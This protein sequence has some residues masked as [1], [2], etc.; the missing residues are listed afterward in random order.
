MLIEIILN[1]ILLVFRAAFATIQIENLPSDIQTVLATLTAYLIDGG[2]V[3]CAY[4]HV[5]YIL[6]LLTFVIA[7]NA[8]MSGYRFL[9]WVL[10]KIPFL[11][12][13]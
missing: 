8:V 4:I 12:I 9:M 2:R 6:A 3:I 11:G 1:F 7:M 5:P 13:D 10:R